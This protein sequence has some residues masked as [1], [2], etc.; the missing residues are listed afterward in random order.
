MNVLELTCLV[1]WAC[2]GVICSWLASQK[3]RSK[4]T[5]HPT[6]LDDFWTNRS[7]NAR[8]SIASNSS[9]FKVTCLRLQVRSRA[10]CFGGFRTSLRSQP[11][12]SR[13]KPI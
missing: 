1:W 7:E 12:D 6:I 10:I 11:R 9:I 8:R 3:L 4:W 13:D 2:S 5:S